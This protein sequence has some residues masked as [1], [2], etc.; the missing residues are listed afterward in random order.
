MEE[1]ARSLSLERASLFNLLSAKKEISE[2]WHSDLL[3][4]EA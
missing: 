3:L 4:P 2:V 1:R